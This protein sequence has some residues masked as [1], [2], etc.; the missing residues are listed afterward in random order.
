MRGRKA[1]LGLLAAA[2]LALGSDPL[3]SPRPVP[4]RLRLDTKALAADRAET[5]AD[6]SETALA[7]ER[8]ELKARLDYLLK[9]VAEAPAG[10][11]GRPAIPV[12][13]KFEMPPSGNV[14]DGMRLAQNLYRDDE[15]D[16]ALR[17]FRL[18]DT[19]QLTREDR[20]FVQYMIATCLRK[21]NKVGDAAVAYR[22]VADAK[23]DEF[24]VECAIWQ[25]SL[26][27]ATQELED[28]RDQLRGRT[29]K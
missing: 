20:A 12:R 6:P 5:A 28:Q 9:R 15:I 13:P 16:A 8:A 21:L 7:A 29:K 19:T 18:I 3:P 1:I 22:E 10:P 26:L 23:D 17:A 14:L 25:L 24:L 27:R 2:P 4:G 11:V